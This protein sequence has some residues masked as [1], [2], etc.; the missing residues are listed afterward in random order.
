M[1]S[2]DNIRVQIT[3]SK[4]LRKKLLQEAKE[5]KTTVSKLVSKLLEDNY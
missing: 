1:I 4:K 3:I 5:K 2:K